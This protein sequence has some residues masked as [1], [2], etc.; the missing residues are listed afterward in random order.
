MINLV[1]M[2]CRIMILKFSF[3][4]TKCTLKKGEWSWRN[5]GPL[6]KKSVKIEIQFEKF[7][8]ERQS[9]NILITVKLIMIFSVLEAVSA[10]SL[11]RPRETNETDPSRGALTLN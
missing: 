9:V 3:Q 11:P 10:R 5:Q 4:I 1:S 7:I 8:E 6:P 2:S